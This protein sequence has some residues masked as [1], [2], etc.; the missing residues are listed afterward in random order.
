[1][2]AKHAQRRRMEAQL[3]QTQQRLHHAQDG[4]HRLADAAAFGGE[5]VLDAAAH[6]QAGH[7]LIDNQTQ[8]MFGGHATRQ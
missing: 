7:V 4:T 3:R 1:M 5:I 8:A 6:P 2:A